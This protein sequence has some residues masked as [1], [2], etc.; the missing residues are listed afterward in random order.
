M[1]KLLRQT[2]AAQPCPHSSEKPTKGLS[3][4]G[5]FHETNPWGLCIPWSSEFPGGSCLHPKKRVV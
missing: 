2:Q 5:C 1:Q 3:L 4:P